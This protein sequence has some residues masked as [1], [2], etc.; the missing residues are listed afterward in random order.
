MSR[1]VLVIDDDPDLRASLRI[2]LESMNLSVIAA[3]DGKSGL[4]S[5]RRHRSRSRTCLR[6][7]HFFPI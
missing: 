5:A 6:R 4:A 3:P 1:T 7:F 2:R